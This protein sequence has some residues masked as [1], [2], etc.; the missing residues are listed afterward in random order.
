MVNANML[1]NP[2]AVIQKVGLGKL[3]L[4]LVEE[5]KVLLIE[6]TPGFVPFYCTNERFSVSC[7]SVNWGKELRL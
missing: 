4:V 3:D 1:S 5:V 6:G 2:S 7:F